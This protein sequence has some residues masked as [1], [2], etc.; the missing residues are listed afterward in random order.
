LL[1]LGVKRDWSKPTDEGG[2][3]FGNT[4]A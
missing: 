2:T 4:D 3:Q 1:A